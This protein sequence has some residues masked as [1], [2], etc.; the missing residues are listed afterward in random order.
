MFKVFSLFSVLTI[1]SKILGLVRD[2]VIAHYF[3]TGLAADA[4][5]MAYLFTGNF[6]IVF[7]GIG[8]PFYSSVIAYLPR[9]SGSDRPRFIRDLIFKTFMVLAALCLLLYFAKAYLL[10]FFIDAEAKPEYFDLSLRNID[11]LLPLILICGPIGISFATLNYCK[12][13]VEPSLSPGFVN[14]ALIITV[15]LLGDFA[16]GL[17]LAIGTSIGGILSL[18]VQL[19][20]LFAC[21][22]GVSSSSNPNDSF[23][24]ILAPILLTTATS[25]VMVFIDSF[26]CKELAEGSWTSLVLANRLIQMPLGVML[27]AFMVP[28][29]PRIGDLIKENNKA[30][31]MRLLKKTLGFL[32]MLSLPAVVIAFFFAE[33]IIRI[34]FERGAFDSSSTLMVSST[35][36]VLAIYV[37]P[38]IFKDSF[39]RTLYSFGD[40]QTALM[41]MIQSIFLKIAVNYV[42]VHYLGWGLQGIALSTI[43]IAVYGALVLGLALKRYL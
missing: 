36:S 10:G 32:S 19:P 13:Y 5:N 22:H 21:Q 11:V 27:T 41:V 34:L 17:A 16:N 6:F 24:K 18:L 35:F 31:V 42:F 30:E 20:S 23:A 2:L 1:I 28:L 37:L 40:S 29:F 14:L 12:K 15:L 26:F 43:V 7:G 38:Y 3:G 8:G 4:F 33:P 25:Q 9:L 39:T